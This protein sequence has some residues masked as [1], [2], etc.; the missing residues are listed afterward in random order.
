[1]LPSSLVYR[2]L[3]QRVGN[4]QSFHLDLRT[5]QGKYLES[6]RFFLYILKHFYLRYINFFLY[7]IEFVYGV[8]FFVFFFFF[9]LVFSLLGDIVL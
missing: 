5:K 6:K 9:T 3:K 2:I 7:A 4:F 8:V 1:M